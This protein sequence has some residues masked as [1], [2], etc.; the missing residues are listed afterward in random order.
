MPTCNYRADVI[1]QN[2]TH[3]YYGASEG[4]F[5]YRH[6]SHTHSFPNQDYKN[7]TELSKH[8]WQLKRNGNDSNLKCSIAA[9]AIP[10][11]CGTRRGGL[12]LKEKYLKA[13]AN[14]NNILN[15]KTELISKCRHRN[16]CIFKN[17][18]HILNWFTMEQFKS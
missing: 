3:E 11:R 9:Y 18:W 1:K 8:I 13:Q 2:E 6:T 7:K 10:C 12:C 17:I 16:K 15:K 14:Q 4:E 5:K